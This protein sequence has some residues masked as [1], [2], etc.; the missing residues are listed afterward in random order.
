MSHIAVWFVINI[1]LD[2]WMHV[3]QSDAVKWLVAQ[4]STQEAFVAYMSLGQPGSLGFV[5]YVG[6]CWDVEA[7]Q[8]HT[9]FPERSLENPVRI[10]DRFCQVTRPK[11]TGAS[12]RCFM[13]FQ[14]LYTVTSVWHQQPRLLIC[15]CM[16]VDGLFNSIYG[17][18]WLCRYASCH[19][20]PVFFSVSFSSV[21]RR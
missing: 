5:W 21:F 20:L 18:L 14:D 2:L 8:K 13:V 19:K 12:L 7:F 3:F 10:L 6:I 1:Q 16:R 15:N 4:V 9:N 17:V 11:P